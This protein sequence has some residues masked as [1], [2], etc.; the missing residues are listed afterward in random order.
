[1]IK[2]LKH[3][4]AT[5]TE[6]DEVFMTSNG[7]LFHKE[8]D[9][10]AHASELPDSRVKSF[11]RDEVDEMEEEVEKPVKTE[12]SKVESTKPKA[13]AGKEVKL[14]P[15]ADKGKGVDADSSKGAGEAAGSPSGEIKE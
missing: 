11:T 5:Y 7:F 9:A 12:K 13:G 2:K 10:K 1:M 4:F 6:S 15:E 3:Y 8:H 14:K